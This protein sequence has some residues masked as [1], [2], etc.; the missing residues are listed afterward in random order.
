MKPCEQQLLQLPFL[1]LWAA[2][3][4]FGWGIGWVQGA[5]RNAS[6]M[7][8]Y[9]TPRTE[10]SESKP[11]SASS[12]SSTVVPLPVRSATPRQTPFA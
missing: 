4:A 7:W 6:T 12:P 1:Y 9:S 5:A 2:Q 11:R 3:W 10:T 8:P